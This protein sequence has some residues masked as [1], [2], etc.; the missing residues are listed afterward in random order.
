MHAK[1]DHMHNDQ[2]DFDWL[3]IDNHQRQILFYLK[4]KMKVKNQ[5]NVADKKKFNNS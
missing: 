4:I 5:Y 1:S 2:A 3:I